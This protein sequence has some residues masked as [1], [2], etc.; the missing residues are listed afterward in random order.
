MSSCPDVAVPLKAWH[1]VTAAFFVVASIV[2]TAPELGVPIPFFQGW[3]WSWL[4]WGDKTVTSYGYLRW[5]PQLLALS[6]ALLAV[7]ATTCC[8]SSV[9]RKRW[10]DRRL[11]VSTKSANSVS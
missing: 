2:C 4:S 7:L 10:N 5:A 3:N 6:S 8:S 11:S 9:R 1:T